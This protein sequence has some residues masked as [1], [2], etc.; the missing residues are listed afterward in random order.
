M[1]RARTIRKL[2]RAA[3]TCARSE[4]VET[5]WPPSLVLTKRQQRSITSDIRGVRDQRGHRRSR[6]AGDR[7]TLEKDQM[8]TPNLGLPY[9]AQGRAQTE[10]THNDAHNLIDAVVQLAVL[11][12]DRARAPWPSSIGARELASAGLLSQRAFRDHEPGFVCT[13][14]GRRKRGPMLRC[15]DW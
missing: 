3:A 2:H 5:S 10:V 11:D 4:Q 1:C 8:P 15:R 9:I 7:F 12:R 14:C 13:A 6:L